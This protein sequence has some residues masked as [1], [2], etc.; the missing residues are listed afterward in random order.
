MFFLGYKTSVSVHFRNM[1]K[2]GMDIFT[3]WN[4][5]PIAGKIWY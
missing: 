2:S 1:G 4:L 5:V 3:V